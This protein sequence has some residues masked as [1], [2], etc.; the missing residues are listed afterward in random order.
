MDVDAMLSRV[1]LTNDTI[2]YVAQRTKAQRDDAT[3]HALHARVLSASRFADALRA[4]DDSLAIPAFLKLYFT[5]QYTTPAMHYGVANEA[6]ARS[7]YAHRTQYDVRETGIWLMPSGMLGASP[8]GI[9]YDNAQSETPIGC[10]EIKCPYTLRNKTPTTFAEH[11]SHTFALTR[12]YDQ[13]Q[14]QM[15]ATNLPWCDLVIWCEAAFEVKRIEASEQWRTKCVP[16]LEHFFATCIMPHMHSMQSQRITYAC[17]KSAYKLSTCACAEQTENKMANANH[18]LSSYSIFN[19]RSFILRSEFEFYNGL[20][21]LRFYKSWFDRQ[22]G[23]F[24]DQRCVMSLSLEQAAEL[25]RVLP[26]IVSDCIE[27]KNKH[28]M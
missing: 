1:P 18:G 17:L 8:D 9:V 16:K 7:A 12:Y 13:I 23:Q 19:T 6:R 5:K 11:M 10:L 26:L 21:N 15:V 25:G 27:I 22:L 14:G 24:S 20:Y 28:G 2:A 3:W 4:A